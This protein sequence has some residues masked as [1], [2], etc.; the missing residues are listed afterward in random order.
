MEDKTVMIVRLFGP[1]L[2]DVSVFVRGLERDGGEAAVC[3]DEHPEV[4]VK[5]SGDGRIV[6]DLCAKFGDAV[7]SIDGRSMETVVGGHLAAGGFTVSTAES[8]T[9]GLVGQMLTSVPGS[10]GF[11]AGGVIA[12]S[13][14]LK[15]AL[16]SVPQEMLDSY[17][18]VSGPV[19]MAMASGVRRLTRTD[20]A[21][22]VSGI[23]G[24]GG[25][26]I[27]KPV[28]TVWF[29]LA[30]NDGAQ[31]LE[32]RFSGNRAEIRRCAAITALDLVRRWACVRAGGNIV[33][34]IAGRGIMN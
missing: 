10:S 32:S 8:C 25:G 13:N 18:A 9:G 34:D 20:V 29:G 12:Y 23:A 2:S 15:T 21:V 3:W 27:E 24:P 1:Q 30:S 7:Y 31:A 14:L 16:L 5:C 22:S 19:V 11:Y 17:G 28:G 4:V 26:T 6:A 33:F